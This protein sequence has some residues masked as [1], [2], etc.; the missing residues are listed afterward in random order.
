MP[1]CRWLPG[2]ASL[3]LTGLPLRPAWGWLFPRLWLLLI[4]FALIGYV[5]WKTIPVRRALAAA[6]VA[7]IFGIGAGLAGARGVRLE[8]P[9]RFKGVAVEPGAIYA[10]SPADSSGGLLHEVIGADRYVIRSRQRWA[11]HWR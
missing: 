6:V 9:A 7:M 10:G 11:A 2:L 5:Q 4:V 1:L 8:P 3:V